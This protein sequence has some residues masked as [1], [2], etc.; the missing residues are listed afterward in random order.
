MQNQI[1]TDNIVWSK[2]L[3]LKVF[4][5]SEESIFNEDSKKRTTQIEKEIILATIVLYGLI[6]LCFF[7]LHIL[8][9]NL[10]VEQTTEY[11]EGQMQVQQAEQTQSN[12]ITSQLEAKD[13]E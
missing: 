8:G 9:M 1:N 11:V 3:N 2:N 13:K 4:S 5:E 6:I 7:A 10:P 12:D